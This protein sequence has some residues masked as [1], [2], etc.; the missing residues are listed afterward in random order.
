MAC[1]GVD[2]AL[3][4]DPAAWRVST[5]SGTFYGIDAAAALL[6]LAEAAAYLEDQARAQRLGLGHDSNHDR[7]PR[8]WLYTF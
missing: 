1:D 6:L 7:S 4:A 5:S 3:L 2:R 8:M